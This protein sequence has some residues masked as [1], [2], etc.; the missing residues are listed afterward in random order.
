MLRRRRANRAMMRRWHPWRKRPPCKKQQSRRKRSPPHA[1]RVRRRSGRDAAHACRLVRRT[2]PARGDGPDGSSGV[3][4]VRRRDHV[5]C[6]RR[7]RHCYCSEPALLRSPR[8]RSLTIAS[9][10]HA[11]AVGIGWAL[12]GCGRA[13]CRRSIRARQRRAFGVGLGVGL[14]VALGGRRDSVVQVRHHELEAHQQA[15][16]AYQRELRPHDMCECDSA[17]GRLKRRTRGEAA[18]ARE[19]VGSGG[20]RLSVL[21]NERLGVNKAGCGTR[22]GWAS[23]ILTCHRR[24]SERRRSPEVRTIRSTGSAPG[25]EVSKQRSSSSWCGRR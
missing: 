5:T 24:K 2:L 8:L 23:E 12:A 19:W 9:S 13:R 25:E 21:A 11:P 10:D 18:S 4:C 20:G 6:E 14:V 3:G 17:R 15:E 16:E 22:L 7:R 1:L